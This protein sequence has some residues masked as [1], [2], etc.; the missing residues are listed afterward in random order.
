MA[1]FTDEELDRR[2]IPIDL[3]NECVDILVFLRRCQRANF[4]FP[5]KCIDE[6]RLYKTCLSNL[7]F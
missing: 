1:I 7:Y 2:Q 3:R 5:F 6:K 4:Y